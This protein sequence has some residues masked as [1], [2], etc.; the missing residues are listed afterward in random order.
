MGLQ[1]KQNI[2]LFEF[3]F[4]VEGVSC[5][6]KVVKETCAVLNLNPCV[7]SV[8]VGQQ[9]APLE[10][11]CA[12][13]GTR[14]HTHIRQKAIAVLFLQRSRMQNLDNDLPS[15][16]SATYGGFAALSAHPN[17]KVTSMPEIS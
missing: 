5:K 12:R 6:R 17:V 2:A 13:F 11:F 7:S 14:R 8:R 1:G 16:D 10:S 15:Y 9:L 4:V 3:E